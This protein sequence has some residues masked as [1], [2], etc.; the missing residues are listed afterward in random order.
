[1]LSS[2]SWPSALKILAFATGGYLLPQPYWHTETQ[3]EVK[4]YKSGTKRKPEVKV[5]K[6]QTE[7]EREVEGAHDRHLKKPGH[8]EGKTVYY[9]QLP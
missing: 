7:R 6:S 4:T 5:N 2:L 1:M 3:Q 8:K 9:S